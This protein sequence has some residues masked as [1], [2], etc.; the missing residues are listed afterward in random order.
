ML[1]V[2]MLTISMLSVIKPTIYIE[3]RNAECCYTEY[4]FNE[5]HYA[6]CRSV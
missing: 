3:Y 5:R 1:N 6:E 2:V 4:R